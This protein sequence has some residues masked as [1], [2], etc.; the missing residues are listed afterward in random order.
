M[1][2]DGSIEEHHKA[3]KEIKASIL[4]F[5]ELREKNV[6]RCEDVFHELYSWSLTDWAT[7]V[8]G[9]LGES[10]NIIKKIHRGDFSLD[11]IKDKLADELA[12]TQLYL[13]LL[14]ARAGIDLSA[15]VIKKFNEVSDKRGS[16]I[17]L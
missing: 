17:K 3:I 16:K 4:T 7:A 13:D 6:Q 12:D 10:C 11:E 1:K 8:A 5:R 14:A 9:E 2:F 15:A